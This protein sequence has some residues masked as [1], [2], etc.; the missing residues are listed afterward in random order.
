MK[1]II[2]PLCFIIVIT[3]L[4]ATGCKNNKWIE[5]QSITYA[6]GNE[7]YKRTSVYSYDITRD[8]CTKEDYDNA[9]HKSRNDMSESS[10]RD[11]PLEIDRKQQL[12]D[13]NSQVGLTYY[14]PI[15]SVGTYG[16]TTFNSLQL[17]YVKI[18]FIDD[19]SLEI[20]FKD[21]INR[22]HSTN[23]KITYFND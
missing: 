11:I 8:S 17:N 15:Y 9:T 7:T 5:V 10:Y 4:F 22:I 6:V 23:Y 14:H 18:R 12:E 19:N 20:A 3:L 13:L 1:K 2:F 21:E 16:T